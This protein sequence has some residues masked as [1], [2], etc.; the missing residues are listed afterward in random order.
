MGEESVRRLLGVALG[1]P[2]S[3]PS[4]DLVDIPRDRVPAADLEAFRKF[5]EFHPEVDAGPPEVGHLHHFRQ[6][7]P[8]RGAAVRLRH[9]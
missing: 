7:T 4:F 9:S 2:R 6:A 5:P 3:H 1:H 8:A